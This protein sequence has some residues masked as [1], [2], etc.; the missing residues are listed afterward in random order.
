[1]RP[2]AA[3]ASSGAAPWAPTTGT[4]PPRWPPASPPRSSSAS[5]PWW[6][7]LSRPLR[8]TRTVQRTERSSSHGERFLANLWQMALRARVEDALCLVE[9]R[10][11]EP[12]TPCM[13][14]TSRR[15]PSQ[16]VPACFPTSVLLTR[17]MASK[18]H[19]EACGDVRLG[20]WQTAGRSGVRTPQRQCLA[21]PL[22]N[23]HLAPLVHCSPQTISGRGLRGPAVAVTVVDDAV[24]GWLTGDHLPRGVVISND[25]QA[26]VDVEAIL[27]DDLERTGAIAYCR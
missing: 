7:S 27:K 14:L 18:R 16:Y 19:G 10:G 11:F 21:R 6:R 26:R 15:L 8:P 5:Q 9:L 4:P 12:L 13:P 20:C 22:A 2:T 25:V 17:R 23:E 1:M 3:S 24:V